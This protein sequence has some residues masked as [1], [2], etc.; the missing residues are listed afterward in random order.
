M[1]AGECPP[2]GVSLSPTVSVRHQHLVVTYE[3]CYRD[4][5]RHVGA[6]RTITDDTLLRLRQPTDMVERRGNSTSRPLCNATADVAALRS[7][8]WLG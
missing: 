6:G 4:V 7:C 1:S 3:S 5:D 2:V 8:V